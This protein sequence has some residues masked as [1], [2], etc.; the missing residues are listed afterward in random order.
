MT[1]V[2]FS[3]SGEM[4]RE[5]ALLTEK[6]GSG[7]S[8]CM[9]Y[10]KFNHD[11]VGSS[12]LRDIKDYCT[13]NDITYLTTLDFFYYAWQRSVISESDI[14]NSLESLIGLDLFHNLNDAVENE[15]EAQVV[16]KHWGHLCHY[17]FTIFLTITPLSVSIFRKY[18]PAVYGDKS[19]S[20]M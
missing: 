10:C 19:S 12:N 5:Y 13:A 16:K 1:V 17:F 3:P 20:V 4:L 8:A 9:A 14:D 2:P 18:T 6:F 11:V 15:V 7:E